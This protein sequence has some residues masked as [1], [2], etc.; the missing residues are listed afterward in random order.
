MFGGDGPL[1]LCLSGGGFR[2]TFFHLGV[3]RLLHELDCLKRVTHVFSVSGGSILAAHLGLNWSAYT[4]GREDAFQNLSDALVR[5]GRDDLRGRIIRRWALL[6]ARASTLQRQYD[7][8]FKGA[9]LRELPPLPTFHFLTTSMTTGRL[10]AFSRDAFLVVHEDGHVASFPAEAQPIAQAVAASS[11]FPPLFPPLKLDLPDLPRAQFPMAE[12]L[13]DGGIFD[14]LGISRLHRL[15]SDATKTGF[16]RIIVSDA[17]ALFDHAPDSRFLLL[18][19]RASRA[20]DILMQ[21]VA[22]LESELWQRE[23]GGRLIV[24]GIGDVV[25]DLPLS[26]NSFRPQLPKI[27][28]LLKGVR[29]DF[30]A[31]DID[32]IRSLVKHGYEVAFQAALASRI[33]MPL[34]EYR[35]QA[36]GKIDERQTDDAL[37]WDPC[38]AAWPDANVMREHAQR[39]ALKKPLLKVTEIL[40]KGSH[41]LGVE[42]S[43]KGERFRDSLTAADRKAVVELETLIAAASRRPIGLWNRRD[44]VSWILSLLAVAIVVGKAFGALLLWRTVGAQNRPA[45]AAGLPHKLC[46][47]T[48]WASETPSLFAV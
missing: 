32:L 37:P 38:P 21:R 8:F 28:R 35:R 10:C 46:P 6:Q 34:D 30:D 22:S 48:R 33:P 14:N 45:Q 11:A 18:L 41:A 16:A 12:Y 4:S 5:F 7:A 9:R 2:A 39:A 43:L 24:L 26:S 44:W 15:V 42:P 47:T 19:S 25:A 13:T 23:P 20:T 29:T 1:A 3:V 36:L 17:S 40:E 31:F 27:Q